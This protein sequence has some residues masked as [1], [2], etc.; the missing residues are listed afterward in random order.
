MP[1]IEIEQITVSLDDTNIKR[2][3]RKTLKVEIMPEEAKNQAIAYSSSNPSVATVD[4]SGNIIGLKSGKA[5]ITVKSK[6]NNVSDSIDVTVYTPVE[7]IQLGLDNLI[8]QEGDTYSIIPVLL[9]SD[10]DSTKL[11]YRSETEDIATVTQDGKI[12][13]V[14]E[15]KTKILVETADGKVR[16]ELQ[17]NVV[18]KLAEGEIKFDENLQI[19]QNEIIGWDYKNMKV[20]QIKGKITT[21]YKVEI[22]DSKGKLLTD[23]EN[24]GT[25]AKIKF[26]DESG[27]VKI[28]YIIILYGDVNG[29]G[30]INSVD[31]L[32]LQRHILEIEKLTGAF[33]KAGNINKNGK[34]P[35]SYDSL[36]IQ[37]HILELKIISQKI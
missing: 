17:V 3:D 31:L 33:I 7:E 36:L 21:N 15:G 18:P 6:S 30:K 13:A 32:V 5:T 29:D 27:S 26:I 10:A 34:N 24:A 22:Y 14:K 12:T 19:N 9:P 2:G 11:N 4:S 1:N 16:T 20:S 25:G 23:T 28:E 35:S 37:R 8:L